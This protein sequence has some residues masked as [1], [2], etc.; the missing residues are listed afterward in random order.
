MMHVTVTKLKHNL[1]LKHLCVFVN[2]EQ[3]FS[4][5]EVLRVLRK[6]FA[7]LIQAPKVD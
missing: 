7:I 6:K 2:L 4:T 1:K 5:K 3:R